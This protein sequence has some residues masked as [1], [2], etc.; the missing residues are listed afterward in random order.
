ML[1]VTKLYKPQYEFIY[2]RGEN[3]FHEWDMPKLYDLTGYPST[4]C[5]N[6]F[7]MD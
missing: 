5:L 2:F 7:K 4:K 3:K 1:V 6:Y